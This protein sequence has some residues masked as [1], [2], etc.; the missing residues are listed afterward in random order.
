MS[1]E[2][3][4]KELLMAKEESDRLIFEI[5]SRLGA[6]LA[7]D[8][9]NS[10]LRAA[11][12]KELLKASDRDSFVRAF[13]AKSGEDYFKARVENERDFAAFASEFI[14]LVSQLEEGIKNKT[15]RGEERSAMLLRISSMSDSWI[16]KKSGAW[17]EGTMNE[18]ALK[19]SLMKMLGE[20]EREV[21]VFLE[22]TEALT[23]ENNQK[24]CERATLVLDKIKA[25]RDAL[26]VAYIPD[27]EENYALI[28]SI[29]EEIASLRADIPKMGTTTVV[30]H[31]LHT[32]D[33]LIKTAGSL[34]VGGKK[35][36]AKHK[37]TGFGAA[38]AENIKSGECD[39]LSA[40]VFV[41]ESL[42]TSDEFLEE[43]R[44]LLAPV[45]LPEM[46]RPFIPAEDA[47]YARIQ[48]A[49]D[50]AVEDGRQARER[51]DKAT[52]ASCATALQ[53]YIKTRDT[54]VASKQAEVTKAMDE[55]NR[56]LARS[57]RKGVYD[58]LMRK[59]RDVQRVFTGESLVDYGTR[60]E[61]M[62]E[63][64]VG[65]LA[66]IVRDYIAAATRDNRDRMDEIDGLFVS[67]KE[68][69]NTEERLLGQSKM[70]GEVLPEHEVDFVTEQI[71][72]PEMDD[73]MLDALFGKMGDAVTEEK[74]KET[75]PDRNVEAEFDAI[76]GRIAEK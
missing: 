22:Y 29:R 75:E 18:T 4:R 63:N 47:H 12:D 61:I 15:L 13:I 65:N 31:T 10:E 23:S 41:L 1:F 45:G 73:A 68:S 46:P 19:S 30:R 6:A 67:I 74:P 3:E 49:I 16:E 9:K 66:E 24:Q 50:R 44:G 20:T 8:S 25:W 76:L 38:T 54:Y 48:A 62:A 69:Y 27:T 28:N 42:S 11:V 59:V 34:P 60:A 64:G 17:R 71:A 21:A 51:G 58:D 26:A 2:Q 53:N 32:I 35:L 33:G 56:I 70:V 39:E 5:R 14:L 40:A 72:T 36:S 52:L 55:Y 7:A 43:M 37:I 57:T